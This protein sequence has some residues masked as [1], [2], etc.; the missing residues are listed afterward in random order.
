MLHPEREREQILRL[1]QKYNIR[2][3]TVSGRMEDGR[4]QSDQE[5]DHV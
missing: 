2:N 5:G 1:V 4:S 3:G